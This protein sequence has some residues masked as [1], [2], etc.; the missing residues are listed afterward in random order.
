MKLKKIIPVFILLS[1]FIA[2][3][4]EVLTKEVH[5]TTTTYKTLG[6]YDSSGKPDYLL[7]KDPISNDLMTY[8]NST[9]PERSDLRSTHPDLLTTKAIADLAITK[10]SDVFLTFISDGAGNTNAMAFYTYASNNPPKSPSDITTITYAFPN[11]G[12]GTP[13]QPGDK[14]KIGR[15]DPGTSVGF[16][17]LQ[18]AWDLTAKKL[19]NDVVHFCS[20]DILN[21]EVDPNL[22]KH[23]VLINY[24]TE[25][26]V[27]IGF[28]DTNRTD[29]R[30]DNDFNDVLFYATVAP[31]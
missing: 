6:A 14:V 25:G 9:L 29:P 10:T 30:C 26:K 15:F 22:K 4:K 19:N 12:Y 7:P 13:L 23:A 8:L 17:I 27:L 20:N 21:P 11:A 28:E 24:P 3:K 31:I 2:C 18:N 5:F 16:V 1:T